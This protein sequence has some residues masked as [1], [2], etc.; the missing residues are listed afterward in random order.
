M[1]LRPASAGPS[2]L[3][4]AVL[5]E[6][7]LGVMSAHL[8]DADMKLGDMAFLPRSRHF[9]LVACRIDW[10]NVAIG[11][12]ARRE[13]GFHFSHVRHV[14]RIGFEQADPDL[15]LQLLTVSFAATDAPAGD[16]LLT[17]AGGRMIKLDVDCLEAEMRDLGPC[18]AVDKHPRHDLDDVTLPG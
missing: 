7:D 1:T 11:Q 14:R 4:F 5:D 16:V 9:A 10:D 6:E 3:H 15:A 2:G 13:T 8:Q 18:W 17:F 12:P